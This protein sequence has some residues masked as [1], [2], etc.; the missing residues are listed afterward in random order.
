MSKQKNK[1]KE[2]E[3]PP[4]AETLKTA[5][6]P[7]HPAPT[8]ATALSDQIEKLRAFMSE[9][10]FGR[11]PGWVEELGP[12]DA[13]I[14]YIEQLHADMA[15][16]RTR[17]AELEDTPRAASTAGESVAVTVP[18][19]TEPD[20][21]A[22]AVQAY[23]LFRQNQA[24]GDFPSWDALDTPTQKLWRDSYAHVAGGGAPRTDYECAVKYLISAAQ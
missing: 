24:E 4:A 5:E 14:A 7:D 19:A 3:A 11:P 17:V 2:P 22:L 10:G 20:H 1:E 18:T 6:P 9:F 23:D 15:T 16:L 21:K 13:A 8:R 12:V